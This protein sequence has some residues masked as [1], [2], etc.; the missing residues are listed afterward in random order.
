MLS[1]LPEIRIIKWNTCFFKKRPQ[2][3]FSYYI[4]TSGNSEVTVLAGVR[5]ILTLT[6]HELLFSHSALQSSRVML[7]DIDSST[8]RVFF[9]KQS[10][11]AILQWKHP[12]AQSSCLKCIPFLFTKYPFS[13][14]RLKLWQS[15]EWK[16]LWKRP[17]SS[18]KLNNIL[19]IFCF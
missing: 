1:E 18:L 2:I 9:S 6:W 16:T 8:K 14:T 4:K 19:G 11:S 5:R 13:W 12:H 10:G 7:D 3:R 17:V 15:K